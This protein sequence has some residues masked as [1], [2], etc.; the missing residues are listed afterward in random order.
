[1]SSA[2]EELIRFHNESMVIIPGQAGHDEWEACGCEV[3]TTVRN[4]KSVE[5]KLYRELE[6]RGVFP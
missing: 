6:S 2:L 5:V 3:A 1:M 4:M